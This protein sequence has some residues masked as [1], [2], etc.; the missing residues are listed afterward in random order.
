MACLAAAPGP[1]LNHGLAAY[2]TWRIGYGGRRFCSRWP[3]SRRID[4][5]RFN[6]GEQLR[7][8]NEAD[9]FA[10]GKVFR[11]PGEIA[12]GDNDGFIGFFGGHQPEHFAD[13]QM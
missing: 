8:V 4:L 6:H 5:D 10:G 3:G 9:G 7:A 13:S 12:G 2:W 11:I 1:A